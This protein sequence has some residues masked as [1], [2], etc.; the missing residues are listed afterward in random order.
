M[1]LINDGETGS[2]ILKPIPSIG[3]N[4]DQMPANEHL[5]MQIARQVYGID[6]AE[7]ALIFFKDGKPAYLTRRFDINTDKTKRA[8]EDFASLGARTPHSHG[9]DYKYVGNYSEL[10]T[11]MKKYIPAYRIEAQKLFKLLVFNYLFSNGDAHFKNFSV[12]ETPDGDFCLSPAYDLLNTH[13][14][15]NDSVFA[16]EDGLLPKNLKKGNIKNQFLILANFAGLTDGQIKQVF[17]KMLANNEKVQQLIKN[18][19]LN[20]KLQKN[21]ILYNRLINN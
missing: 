14:H 20:T 3:K 7:N 15:I 16:L 8:V 10:F 4:L 12:V 9:K 19:F 13:I 21:Y 6:T 5:T 2:Y 17:D 1:R 18:S 11:I